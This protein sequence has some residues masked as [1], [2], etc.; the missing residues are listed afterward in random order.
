MLHTS[1]LSMCGVVVFYTWFIFAPSYAV[2]VHGMDAQHFL[3]AG[4]LAHGVFL[5]AIPVMGQLADR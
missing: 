1:A 5:G 4:L 3:V 2:A